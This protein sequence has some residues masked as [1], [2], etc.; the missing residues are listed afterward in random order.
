[1][2]VLN[3]SNVKLPELNPTKVNK[4]GYYLPD[5]ESQY[6]IQLQEFYNTSAIHSSFVNTLSRKLLGTN[7]V[8]TNPEDVKVITDMELD[9]LIAQTTMDLAYYG[10]FAWEIFWNQLHTKILKI[11]RLDVSNVYI[12][13]IDP[14]T[15]STN[16]YYYSTNWNEWRNREIKTIQ[17]YSDNPKTDD[18]QILYYKIPTAGKSIYAKPIYYSGLKWVYIDSQVG[19][20]YANLVKNNFVSNTIININSVMDE[21][22]QH[23]FEENI[24]KKFTSTENAGSILVIYSDS[25][26]NAPE[27]IKFN[28]EEEDK[29]Y[30]WL[31]TETINRLIIAHQIPSPAIAGLRVSG[32][33]GNSQ[34]IEEAEQIYKANVVYPIREELLNQL[35]ELNPYFYT[36]LT[37]IQI[38][39]VPIFKNNTPTQ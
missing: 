9:T 16:F 20:Y 36:P 28:N 2:Y 1:M 13:L 7:L 35:E 18:H 11:K 26:D 25:K 17:A 39:D 21:E 5:P 6:F 30:E 24:K 37:T 14:D 32:Q 34:E 38:D 27:I 4:G 29:K 12:G 33:L 8:S 22:K 23:E 19:N 10:G 3:L 31:S 15:D